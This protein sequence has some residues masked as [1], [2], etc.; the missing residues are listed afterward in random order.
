MLL[1][2]GNHDAFTKSGLTTKALEKYLKLRKFKN[3]QTMVV[4]GRHELL[5]E[6]N[7]FEVVDEIITWLT[8]E[9]LV[10]TTSEV[11]ELEVITAKPDV[12]VVETQVVEN[13]PVQEVK[14]ETEIKKETIQFM[15]AEEDLLIRTNK[16][17]E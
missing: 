1:L 8:G 11:V 9:E 16:E 13:V 6:K 7:R 14:E 3:V 5:F 2:S 10:K 4:E 15:D 12:E 17:E